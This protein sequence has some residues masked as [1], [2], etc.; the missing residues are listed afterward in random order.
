MLCLRLLELGL[1][2]PAG[3]V[4]VLLA[5]SEPKAALLPHVDAI[6]VGILRL[7][8]EAVIRQDLETRVVRTGPE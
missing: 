4:N 3:A 7:L 6:A 8:T 1:L 5:S 2:P